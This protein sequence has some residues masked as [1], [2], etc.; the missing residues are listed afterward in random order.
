MVPETWLTFPI[1]TLDANFSRTL[2]FLQQS[3]NEAN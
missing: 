1:L 2:S 3:L